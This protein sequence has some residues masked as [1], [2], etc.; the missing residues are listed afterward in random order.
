MVGENYYA[1]QSFIPSANNDSHSLAA[2]AAI[3]A[4]EGGA[5]ADEAKRRSR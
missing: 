2:V 4:H 3:D 1:P 5:E